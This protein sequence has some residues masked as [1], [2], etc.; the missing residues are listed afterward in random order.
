MTE[1]AWSV[2]DLMPGDREHE[3]AAIV[4]LI[5]S[6][7]VPQNRLASIIDGYG[8]AVKLVQLSEADRLFAAPEAAHA[9]IGGVTA[10]DVHR[11]MPDARAWLNADFDVR[12]ILDPSYPEPLRDI[13]NAPPVLFVK[14]TWPTT[15]AR[16]I[17]VV[18]ARNASTAGL[19]RARRLSAELTAAGYVIL[20]GLARGIDSAAHEAALQS[21]GQTSAVMGTGLSQVFPPENTA[22]AQSILENG[23]ALISQFF[24]HQAPTRWTFPMR[25]VV[26][27]GLALATTVVE[28]AATSGARLQARVALQHGRTVFLLRSLVESHEWAYK[29]ATEGAYGTKAIVVSTTKDITDRL[30]GAAHTEPVAFV[31]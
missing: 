5:R 13:F 8:S 19:A 25:N 14:G 17:A 16:A 23:G 15:A 28:A 7:I 29:Y 2:Q 1:R 22:L 21:G 4:A 27:S 24:P 20:S 31:S 3:L 6:G 11:A 12:T 18:G 9:I 30:E 26:M 10:E